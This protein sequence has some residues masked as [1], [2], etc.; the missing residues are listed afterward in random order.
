MFGDMFFDEDEEK[1]KYYAD[2]NG[3]QKVSFIINEASEDS[4]GIGVEHEFTPVLN[5]KITKPSDLNLKSQEELDHIQKTIQQPIFISFGN[6][7]LKYF[8][9]EEFYSTLE[10]IEG[11]AEVSTKGIPMFEIKN[12]NYQNVT[13]EDIF[14]ELDDYQNFILDEYTEIMRRK[15][16]NYPNVIEMPFGVGYIYVS[17]H[18]WYDL[19]NRFSGVLIDY[20]GSYHFWLTLP[21]SKKDSDY[22]HQKAMYL[23]QTIE[24]LLCAL[25]GS[26]DPRSILDGGEYIEGSYRSAVN[27]YAGYGTSNLSNLYAIFER[28]QVDILDVSSPKTLGKKESFSYID[29]LTQKFTTGNNMDMELSTKPQYNIFSSKKRVIGIDFRKKKDIPG[30]EFRIWD[31]FPQKY[32]PHILRIYL[33]IATRAYDIDHTL[34]YAPQ[35]DAWQV[36]MYETLLNGY[37]GQIPS[38]YISLINKQFGVKLQLSLHRAEDVM[39]SLINQLYPKRPDVYD[40]MTTYNKPPIVENIN[41]DSWNYWFKNHPAKYKT[42]K[43]IMAHIKPNKKYNFTALK[44]KLKYEPI[45]VDDLEKI[46]EY[47]VSNKRLTKTDNTYVLMNTNI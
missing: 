39:T 19:Y 6:D 10:S 1:Y 11:N 45:I 18:T 21:S 16:P 24:P 12:I 46:L 43:K 3:E 34:V 38:E 17:E 8:R 13:V 32:L 26:A 42:I 22:I 28:R 41:K 15:I 5:K 4:W 33:L 14:E 25:Y 35:N 36:A 20:T 2:K 40:D 44:S 27:P 29:K 9:R 23:I 47:L 7:G 31:H 37:T 30:F